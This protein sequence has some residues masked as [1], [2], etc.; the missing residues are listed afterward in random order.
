MESDVARILLKKPGSCEHKLGW[1]PLKNLDNFNH[2]VA[3]LSSGTGEI[4]VKRHSSNI[5]SPDHFLH[6]EYCYGF[7]TAKL[8]GSM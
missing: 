5:M 1:E 7:V 2:N 8:C 4:I 6:C 3:A